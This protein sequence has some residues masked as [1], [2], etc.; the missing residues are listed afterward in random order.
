MCDIPFEEAR[1]E[2]GRV[3]VERHVGADGLWALSAPP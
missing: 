1:A 2:L 3:A